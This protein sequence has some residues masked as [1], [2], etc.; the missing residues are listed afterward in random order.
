MAVSGNSCDVMYKQHAKSTPENQKA[1]IVN[2]RIVG[3]ITTR[4]VSPGG[5]L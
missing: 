3:R 5:R 1:K 4:G 2:P